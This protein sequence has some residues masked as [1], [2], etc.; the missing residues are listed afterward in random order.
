MQEIQISKVNLLGA[1]GLEEIKIEIQ[2]ET[3]FQIKVE[4]CLEVHL[5]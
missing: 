5:C 4:S 2:L 1:P 3:V